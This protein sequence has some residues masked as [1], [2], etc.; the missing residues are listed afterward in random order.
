MYEFREGWC[1]A[2]KGEK[3]GYIQKFS[4]KVGRKYPL[5]RS[6]KRME[7]NSKM[8][9]VEIQCNGLDGSGYRYLYSCFLLSCERVLII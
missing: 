1:I 7:D 9:F 4:K 3:K 2:T 8:D 5:V 6:R